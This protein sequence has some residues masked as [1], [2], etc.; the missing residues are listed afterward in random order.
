[1]WITF[2]ILISYLEFSYGIH[3]ER[4]LALLLPSIPPKNISEDDYLC[5]AFKTNPKEV[6]YITEFKPYVSNPSTIHHI[7]IFGCETPDDPK[8]EKR[9]YVWNCKDMPNE[10]NCGD[11]RAK[12]LYAWS[13]N[14]PTYTLPEGVGF[15]VGGDTG[16]KY[17]V[18]HVHYIN[19]SQI[20]SKS[21][22]IQVVH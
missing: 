20:T 17:L 5:T 22:F 21:Q 2:V 3:S 16:I 7:L 6:E 14:A 4:D 1:M 11:G 15:K 12:T 10:T 19:T 18:L 9:G 13:R 8:G